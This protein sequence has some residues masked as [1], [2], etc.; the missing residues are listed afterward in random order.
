MSMES[1]SS[2]S[3]PRL[4]VSFFRAQ[5]SSILSTA[6]DFGVFFLLKDIFG[7]YYVIANAVGALNT[8]GIYIIT[9]FFSIDPNYSKVIISILV[10]I[11]YNF[12]LQKYFVFK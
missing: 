11:C 6:V 4:L 7:V 3:T 2:K 10:G 5:F 1:N 8:A 9:E 12:L